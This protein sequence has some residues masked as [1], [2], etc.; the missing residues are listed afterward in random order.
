MCRYMQLAGVTVQGQWWTLL[1]TTNPWTTSLPQPEL[2]SKAQTYMTNQIG[3]AE[4]QAWHLKIVQNYRCRCAQTLLLRVMKAIGNCGTATAGG[5]RGTN[6]PIRWEQPTETATIKR[7]HSTSPF[8]KLQTAVWLGKRR[9]SILAIN[10]QRNLRKYVTH[11]LE[12][13]H[14]ISRSLL[15]SPQQDKLNE[16]GSSKDYPSCSRK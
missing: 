10:E 12:Q 9:S 13:L 11:A 2:A 5:L 8:S 1:L 3:G 14:P 7:S 6:I 4:I 15:A 16:M